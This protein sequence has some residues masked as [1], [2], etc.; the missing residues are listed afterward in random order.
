MKIDIERII[1]ISKEGLNVVTNFCREH[2]FEVTASGI[3]IGL[4]L[5]DILQRIGRRRERKTYEKSAIKSQ[6]IM[7]MHEAEIQE[8]KSTLGISKRGCDT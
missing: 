7:R 4:G 2:K 8:I 3:A 6:T 5:D 1:K